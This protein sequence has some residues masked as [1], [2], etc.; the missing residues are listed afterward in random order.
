MAWTTALQQYVPRE[1][2]GRVAGM[3]ALGSFA[4]IPVGY[5]LTGWA[6]EALGAPTVFL[7]GGGMT[8]LVVLLLFAGCPAMH[9]L[10]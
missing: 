2:L 6:T 7:M 10:D 3:D 5:A 8:A 1:Q 4:L 9:R